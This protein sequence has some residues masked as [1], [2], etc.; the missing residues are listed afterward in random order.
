MRHIHRCKA[1]LA[2][3]RAGCGAALC[4]CMHNTDYNTMHANN[5]TRPSSSSGGNRQPR[6]HRQR[7]SCIHFKHMHAA[8]M[9][10]TMVQLNTLLVRQV[11][12]YAA[13]VVLRNGILDLINLG[14]V[15]S[16]KLNESICVKC[17][18]N[19]FL[20]TIT[21]PTHYR[22][23]HDSEELLAPIKSTAVQ[24]HLTRIG[25]A[26]GNTHTPGG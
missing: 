1:T 21:F 15:E 9:C 22:L 17:V 26:A 16:P 3:Q 12:H 25:H 2:S 8:G 23:G 20:A 14:T 11:H 24:D 7:N 18:Y 13:G 5:N 6:L 19:N 4:E 10:A